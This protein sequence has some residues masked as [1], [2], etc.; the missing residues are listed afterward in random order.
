VIATGATPVG[1]PW[2]FT[3]YRSEGIVDDRGEVAEPKGLPCIRLLLTRPPATNPTNGSAFCLAPGK[4]AFNVSSVP[5]VDDS[6][7]QA[8]VILYGF[9]PRTAASVRLASARGG[10]LRSDTMSGG[11]SFPGSI[12][13]LTAPPETDAVELDWLDRSGDPAGARLDASP[14]FSRR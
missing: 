10:T 5:V 3:S 9:A 2:R 8:E 11:S 7:G 4:R 13:V 1:G 12:W 14:H 6:S